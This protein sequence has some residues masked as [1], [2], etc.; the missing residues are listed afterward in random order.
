MNHPMNSPKPKLHL[1]ESLSRTC[2]P[3]CGAS[4]RSRKT[5]DIR[6]VTCQRCLTTRETVTF[7]DKRS[8]LIS[9]I[10]RAVEAGDSIG[11]LDAMA[12]RHVLDEL[13]HLQEARDLRGVRRRLMS[14]HRVTRRFVGVYRAPDRPDQKIPVCEVDGQYVD[15]MD[16]VVDISTMVKVS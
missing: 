7:A 14:D 13:T 2:R 12:L 5:R 11:R 10:R 9:S 16:R 4:P 3:A 1:A 15:V 8:A 6:Q